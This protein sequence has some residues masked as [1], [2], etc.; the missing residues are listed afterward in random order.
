LHEC[1]PGFDFALPI[2]AVSFHMFPYVSITNAP[3]ASSSCVNCNLK[4]ESHTPSGTEHGWV[5]A[6]AS[7]IMECRP[8]ADPQQIPSY[9]HSNA[10]ASK[11][12][13]R[14]SSLSLHGAMRVVWLGCGLKPSQQVKQPLSAGSHRESR[15]TSASNIFRGENPFAARCGFLPASC[16]ACIRACQQLGH[17]E[18]SGGSSLVFVFTAALPCLGDGIG[19][20]A[21]LA[22]E[23][24]SL[25]RSVWN[26]IFRLQITVRMARS[27]RRT[28]CY[29][30]SLRLHILLQTWGQARPWA[31]NEA[32]G[33]TF[34]CL[35]ADSQRSRQLL[36][37]LQPVLVPKARLEM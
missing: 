23:A 26:D 8:T 7:N 13:E 36:R 27:S 15:Q 9:P 5:Q 3:Q 11:Q 25:T 14:R 19:P 12:K 2:F 32:E 28:S 29:W 6:F 18:P 37:W 20:Q 22:Q 10:K 17:C 4:A 35:L 24:G 16:A 34:A 21:F 33:H 30:Q 31:T 1:P